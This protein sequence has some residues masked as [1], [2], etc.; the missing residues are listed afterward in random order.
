MKTLKIKWITCQKSQVKRGKWNIFKCDTC[1]SHDK[2]K[3]WHV[4]I[5]D[6]LGWDDQWEL[7]GDIKRKNN[8]MERKTKKLLS[9]IKDK[10]F[11]PKGTLK[12]LLG[13][14]EDSV[15][16]ASSYDIY[17]QTSFIVDKVELM[18]DCEKGSKV[19]KQY[20]EELI[21][22]LEENT[23]RIKWSETKD[24][25][26]DDQGTS[27]YNMFSCVNG[28]CVAYTDLRGFDMHKNKRLRVT[29]G[30]IE[31]KK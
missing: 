21:S 24:I 8:E 19:Y 13:F 14:V 31:D 16:D 17:R 12:A 28:G 2:N 5:I 6:S 20:E 25:L 7:M 29:I 27:R 22:L 9:D 4:E 1:K 26:L 11:Y 10:E 30:V 23:P 15:T 18:H 3:P